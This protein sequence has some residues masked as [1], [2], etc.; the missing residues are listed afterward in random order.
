MQ[1]RTPSGCGAG[2]VALMTSAAYISGP[3][4]YVL[5]GPGVQVLGL[6]TTFLLVAV[7]VFAMG[8]VAAV[9]AVARDGHGVG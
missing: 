2:V 3:L 1:Q 9:A 6:T 8:V 7:V 4:G 5:V